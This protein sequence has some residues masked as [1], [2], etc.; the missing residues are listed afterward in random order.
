MIDQKNQDRKKFKLNIL[1]DEFT[2]TGE[3][4]QE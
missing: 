3:C 4:S 2:V 1:G